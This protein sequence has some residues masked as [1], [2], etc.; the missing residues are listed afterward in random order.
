[1]EPARIKNLSILTLLLLTALFQCTDKEV[2]K[3]SEDGFRPNLLVVQTDEHNFRTLGCY[4]EQLSRE[5]AFIW[6]EDNF[7]ETPNIDFLAIP[8][9]KL[10][11]QG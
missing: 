9:S 8:S 7:V 11:N 2:K 1:M 6:G 4:R 10:V 5:Q 3:E